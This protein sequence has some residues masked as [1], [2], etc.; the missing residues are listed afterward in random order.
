MREALAHL[1][2]TEGL[3]QDALLA[4]AEGLLGGSCSNL[5]KRDYHEQNNSDGVYKG[6]GKINPR[7]MCLEKPG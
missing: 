4:V 7:K 6:E 1:K 2:A 5:D 3:W